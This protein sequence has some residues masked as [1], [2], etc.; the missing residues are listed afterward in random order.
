GRLAG[1]GHGRLALARRARPAGAEIVAVG[2]VSPAPTAR[3]EHGER[4]VEAL[5]YDLGRIFVVAVFVGPFAR[6]QRAFE[7]NLRAL[8]QILLD[9]LAQAFVENDDAVPLGFFLA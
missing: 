4:R 8:L 5:E 7:V 6:L 3:I 9:D 1:A 2:T